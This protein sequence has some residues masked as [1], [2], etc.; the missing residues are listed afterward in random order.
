[1]I[2]GIALAL[3]AGQLALLRSWIS[4]S[5]TRAQ[6]S[7]EVLTAELHALDRALSA[8]MREV[9]SALEGHSH[10]RAS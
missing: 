4:A 8:E 3:A 10:P 1:M 9:R 7:S 6:A 5:D 2:S